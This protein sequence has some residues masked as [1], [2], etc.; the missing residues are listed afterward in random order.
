M[1]SWNETCMLSNL[2]IRWGDRV[3][4]I[5]LVPEGY[6]TVA[7]Y[8]AHDVFKPF[9]LPLRGKYDDYGTVEDIDNTYQA[10]A[11]LRY[12]QEGIKD[13]VLRISESYK[14][15]SVKDVPKVIERGKLSKDVL[16]YVQV[17]NGGFA[18]KS[19][20]KDLHSVLVHEK[21]FD[22]IVE[23]VGARQSSFNS[24]TNYKDALSKDLRGL[25]HKFKEDKEQQIECFGS[26]SP[27][28]ASIG[29]EYFSANRCVKEVLSKKAYAWYVKLCASKK[30]APDWVNDSISE[31]MLF[32]TALNYMRKALQPTIGKGSQCYEMTLHCK[33]S[34]FVKDYRANAFKEYSEENIIEEGENEEEY[35]EEFVFYH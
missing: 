13:K 9:F 11:T 4:W 18:G 12:F 17:E 34:D 27:I 1:G 10:K 35:G 30:G 7:S 5:P 6:G 24:N 33:V 28:N 21:L 20:S 16:E 29:E 2:P 19:V 26:Y 31:L 25:S 22:K 14:I 3:V 15:D 23:N 8:Y 32:M